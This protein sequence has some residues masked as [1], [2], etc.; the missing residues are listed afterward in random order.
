MKMVMVVVVMMVVVVVAVVAV[1]VGR[2]NYFMFGFVAT[3]ISWPIAAR[4][5][6]CEDKN[7]CRINILQSK[8]NC[9]L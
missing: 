1:V 6:N 2:S 4:T 8:N 9:H 3:T 7:Y 5:V